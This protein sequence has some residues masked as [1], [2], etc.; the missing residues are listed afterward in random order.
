MKN[1][2][3]KTNW[4][5][6]YQEDGANFGNEIALSTAAHTLTCRLRYIE[7]GENFAVEI[8]AENGAVTRLNHTFKSVEDAIK[9]L[10]AIEEKGKVDLNCWTQQPKEMCYDEWI[11][12]TFEAVYE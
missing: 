7:V 12:Q 9:T 6:Q 3:K 2:I 8:W 4:K 11:W 10:E 1:Q 5:K